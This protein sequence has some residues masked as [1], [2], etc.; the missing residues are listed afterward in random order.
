MSNPVF[1]R[2]QWNK[3]TNCRLLKILPRVPKVNVF[4]SLVLMS[5]AASSKTGLTL[6]TLFYSYQTTFAL[7]FLYFSKAEGFDIAWKLSPME[8]ICMECQILFSGKRKQNFQN[9]V[10]WICPE[11]SKGYASKF[12]FYW[13][14][15]G[16]SSG[17]LF[18]HCLFLT[19]SSRLAPVSSDYFFSL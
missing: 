9:V 7:F 16:G 15:Q 11:S 4:C 6:N 2:K 13:P 14:F 18:S 1:W 10:C 3:I 8:I 19:S 5:G 12:N 17:A